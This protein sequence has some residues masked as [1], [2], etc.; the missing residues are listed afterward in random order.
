MPELLLGIWLWQRAVPGLGRIVVTT[1]TASRPGSLTSSLCHLR[2]KQN[3]LGTH[4]IG[5]KAV[6]QHDFGQVCQLTNFTEPQQHVQVFDGFHFRVVA[7]DLLQGRAPHQGTGMVDNRAPD[8]Q[9]LL[10]FIIMFRHRNPLHRAALRVNQIKGTADTDY[11]RMLAEKLHLK[12][13]PVGCGNVIRIHA[14]QNSPLACSSI[15]LRV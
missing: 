10:D 7:A 8:Q 6:F 12:R 4:R 14:G 9:H 1:N 2:L 13:Q 5:V 3:I 15:S 11:L